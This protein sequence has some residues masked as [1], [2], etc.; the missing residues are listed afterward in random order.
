MS[1]AEV[2]AER[3]RRRRERELEVNNEHANPEDLSASGLVEIQRAQPLPDPR[4]AAE[5]MAAGIDVRNA[6]RM[7]LPAIAVRRRVA[8][9]LECRMSAWTWLEEFATANAETY[10]TVAV[11]L[12]A[13]EDDPQVD[14]LRIRVI[15]PEG[16]LTK[17]KNAF[18]KLVT[19]A[20]DDLR[21][22]MSGGRSA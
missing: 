22:F 4:A 19:N 18:R 12:E 2:S 11:R 21:N 10:A 16:D 3:A 5:A 15:F 8:L 17:N 7:Y 1:V 14:E 13:H 6:L 20:F 9:A